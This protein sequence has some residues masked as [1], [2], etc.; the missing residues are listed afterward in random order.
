MTL[1]S[2]VVAASEAPADTVYRNGRIYTS[3]GITT[4]LDASADAANVAAY[5]ALQRQG[6]LTARAHF[7][8]EIKPEAGG[9]PT[10]LSTRSCNYGVNMTRDR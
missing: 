3:Q 10:G 5:A 9:I 8:I 7:A 6:E 2:V 1:W 4:F